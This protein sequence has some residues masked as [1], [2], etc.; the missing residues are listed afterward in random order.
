MQYLNKG[1]SINN[2][3]KYDFSV[4]YMDKSTVKYLPKMPVSFTWEEMLK[5]SEEFQT[6]YAKYKDGATQVSIAGKA[7]MYKDIKHL[8]LKALA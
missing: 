6:F 4:K 3:K 7:Y 8:T 2:E 1:V 5:K